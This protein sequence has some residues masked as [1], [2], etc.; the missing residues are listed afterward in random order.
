MKYEKP[1]M[2]LVAFENLDIITM[3]LGGDGGNDELDTASEENY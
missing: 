1:F 3:S 2:E